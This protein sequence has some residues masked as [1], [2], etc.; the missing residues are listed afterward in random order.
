MDEVDPE[1]MPVRNRFRWISVATA[2]VGA[3]SVLFAAAP[4][5]AAA[6][7]HTAIVPL[8]SL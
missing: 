6:G 1:G 8:C 7:G 5:A 3:V 2:L 4:V